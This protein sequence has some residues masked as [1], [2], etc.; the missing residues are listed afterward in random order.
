MRLKGEEISEEKKN[1][2]SHFIASF[3]EMDLNFFTLTC[4]LN[5]LQLFGVSLHIYI[6]KIFLF[7][8]SGF[9]SVP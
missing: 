5:I 8:L 1:A 7:A 3:G 9:V 4:P 6:E 2:S